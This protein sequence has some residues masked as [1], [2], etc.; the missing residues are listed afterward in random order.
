MRPFKVFVRGSPYDR[1]VVRWCRS[2]DTALTF[3]D[4]EGWY[5]GFRLFLN[6]RKE[7]NHGGRTE[8]P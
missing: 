2:A 4:S 5:I 8:T 6:P 7:T 3:S 1:E